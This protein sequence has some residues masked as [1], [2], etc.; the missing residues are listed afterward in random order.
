[1]LCIAGLTSAQEKKLYVLIVVSD[2]DVCPCDMFVFNFYTM[3][4]CNGSVLIL[5]CKKERRKNSITVVDV[6][7]TRVA[8]RT[9]FL[10]TLE[11]Q[12][13]IMEGQL[14]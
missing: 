11:N 5:K 6:L 10:N 1:M 12:F 2:L 13:L 4:M 3:R 8:L 14:P 9:C 7:F